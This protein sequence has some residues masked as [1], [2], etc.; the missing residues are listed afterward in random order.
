MLPSDALSRVQ[1]VDRVW[2]AG[3]LEMVL[4]DQLGTFDA[5]IASHVIEHIV[6]PIAFFDSASRL[7]NERG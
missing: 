2:T 7:L 4:Q 5:I 3:P 1:E 6:D